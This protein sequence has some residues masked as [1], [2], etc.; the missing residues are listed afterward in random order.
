MLLW[1]IWIIEELINFFE[2]DVIKAFSHSLVALIKICAETDQP[3]KIFETV[4][5]TPK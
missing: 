4:D 3:S 2:K 5:T 1:Q